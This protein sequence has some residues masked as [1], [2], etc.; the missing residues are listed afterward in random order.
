M[1]TM[2]WVKR[3]VAEVYESQRAQHAGAAD[4]LVMGGLPAARGGAAG[5]LFVGL[6]VFKRGMARRMDCASRGHCGDLG[7]GS[8]LPLSLYAELIATAT[9]PPGNRIRPAHAA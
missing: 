1:K 3:E 2:N 4:A 5:H 7:A 6:P 8:Q 9:S